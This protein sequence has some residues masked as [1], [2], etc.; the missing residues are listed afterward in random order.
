MTQT[1]LCRRDRKYFY[2]ICCGA[3]CLG[4]VCNF[5]PT[6]NLYSNLI[7]FISILTGF[8]ITSF[9]MLFSS[10]IVKGLYKIKDNE[11]SYITLKHRLKNY[12]K[13]AFNLA[14]LSIVIIG[15]QKKFCVLQVQY[16]YYILILYAYRIWLLNC[17]AW[18]IFNTLYLCLCLYLAIMI[19][20]FSFRA[21]L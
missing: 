3:I 18:D 9:A 16:H 17:P 12:Y 11:N 1:L 7:T 5:T 15:W 13:F 4:L 21:I 10:S 6:T 19:I 8:Q 14:L 2:T 20:L